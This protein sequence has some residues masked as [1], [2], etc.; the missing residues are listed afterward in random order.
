MLRFFQYTKELSSDWDINYANMYNTVEFIYGALTQIHSIVDFH[1]T[2]IYKDEYE[3]RQELIDIDKEFRSL[4]MNHKITS[5]DL[6]YDIYYFSSEYNK[7]TKESGTEKQFR[8]IQDLL[9][10]SV[11]KIHEDSKNE[12]FNYN[13]V[14]R[15]RRIIIQINYIE[16]KTSQI[17]ESLKESVKILNDN[18]ENLENIRV[19]VNSG[20]E[21]KKSL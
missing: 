10:F 12:N 8:Q 11:T 21:K 16:S 6:Y 7:I 1:V 20:L 15:L 19:F 13:Y 2:D 14:E 4:I 18:I 17:A 9:V 3:I 5:Q